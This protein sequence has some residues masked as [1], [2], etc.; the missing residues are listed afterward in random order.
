[1]K[2]KIQLQINESTSTIDIYIEN[3]ETEEYTI[4]DTMLVVD[5]EIQVEQL[6]KS[7]EYLGYEVSILKYTPED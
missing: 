7:F 1:M 3:I 2:H 5:D 4:F 6:K